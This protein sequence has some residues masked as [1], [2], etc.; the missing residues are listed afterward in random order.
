MVVSLIRH[1]RFVDSALLFL[2]EQL[3]EPEIIV[4][5][6]TWRQIYNQDWTAAVETGHFTQK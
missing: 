2:P 5:S 1:G 6:R 4:F 3:E